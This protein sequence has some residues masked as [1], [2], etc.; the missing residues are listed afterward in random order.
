MRWK[1]QPKNI[2]RCFTAKRA[3]KRLPAIAVFLITAMAFAVAYATLQDRTSASPFRQ[4]SSPS[5][6]WKAVEQAM[7]K[8]GAMQPGDVFKFAFPR[9][10]LKVIAAGVQIKPALAL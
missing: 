6:E 4:Q 7:G 9:S 10:D 1:N 2:N 3:M 5:A 8:A